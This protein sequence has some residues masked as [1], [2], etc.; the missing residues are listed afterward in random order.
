MA[1]R[2][3]IQKA[4]LL[5]A[6]CLVI[7]GARLYSGR[8]LP[9]LGGLTPISRADSP[10]DRIALTF[11][12]TWGDVELAEVLRTLDAAGLKATFFAGHHWA[13]NHPDLLLAMYTGGHEIGTLGLKV[14]DLTALSRPEIEQQLAA[15]Q[16]LLQRTLGAGA[17]LFRPPYGRWNAQVLAAAR[18][19]GLHTVTASLDA[20][21]TVWPPPPADQIVRRVVRRAQRGDIVMLSASDFAHHTGDAL[22]AIIKGLQARGFKLVPVSQLIPPG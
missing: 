4:G 10:D 5:F 22:P 19:Q 12:V 11:D 7:V 15:A 14:I 1:R 16:A 3:L 13:A 2:E 18:S 21:D 6:A 17:R 9:V 20:A 8:L